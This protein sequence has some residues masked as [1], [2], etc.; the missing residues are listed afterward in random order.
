[1]FPKCGVN[2]L[3]RIFIKK[4]ISLWGHSLEHITRNQRKNQLRG[5][6]GPLSL[7]VVLK[8]VGNIILNNL[9]PIENDPYSYQLMEDI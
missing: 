3:S 2:K 9:G 6:I 5:H 1:M 8:L 7:N 4:N